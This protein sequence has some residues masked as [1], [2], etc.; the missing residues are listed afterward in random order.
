MDKPLVTF[1]RRLLGL[2]AKESVGFAYTFNV[3]QW[4]YFLNSTPP[5]AN[6]L[7]GEALF[8]A[9]PCSL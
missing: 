4:W 6:A 2:N 7:T 3:M 1:T 5:H 8:V 9:L